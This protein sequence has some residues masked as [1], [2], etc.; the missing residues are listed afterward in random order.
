MLDAFKRLPE[1]GFL[2]ADLEDD[3]H[4]LASRYR[5]HI[6]PHEYTLVEENGVKLL[7]GPAGG[8]CAITSRELNKRVGGF[9]QDKKQVFWLE[10]EAYIADLE[11]IGFRRG[12]ARRPQGPSHGRPALHE[13]LQGEG[14]V[15]EALGATAGA[16]GRSQA[17]C[18][19]TFRSCAA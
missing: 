1:I 11:Q 7:H 10:D 13:D 19:S 9:R 5:H 3:P 2:A 6:R 17:S 4:D 15:L 12:R 14:R 8:G 16:E 18:S